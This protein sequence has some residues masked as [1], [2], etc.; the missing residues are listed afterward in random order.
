MLRVQGLG[1][2]LQGV[3]FRFRVQQEFDAAGSIQGCV[4]EG[5]ESTVGGLRFRVLSGFG[6]VK[7]GLRA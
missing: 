4:G 5:L 6:L 2:C 1:F 7:L 3:A